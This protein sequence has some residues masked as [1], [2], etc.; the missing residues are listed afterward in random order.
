MCSL[1]RADIKAQS[2]EER[3]AVEFTNE[4]R[5]NVLKR[6]ADFYGFSVAYPNDYKDEPVTVKLKQVDWITV[7]E[8]ALAGSD[9]TFTHD[10]STVRL[11][12]KDSDMRTISSLRHSVE[13]EIIENEKYRQVII[14]LAEIKESKTRES[15]YLEIL[16]LL[17]NKDIRGAQLLETLSIK[18]KANQSLETTTMAVT[19]TASQPSRQP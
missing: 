10:S 13:S 17:K 18:K 16:E 6:V 5:S 15:A 4:P 2:R 9:Y 14:E 19:P 7:V 12:R 1:G 11:F 3:I 8:F